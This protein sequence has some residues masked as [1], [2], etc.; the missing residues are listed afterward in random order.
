MLTVALPVELESAIVTAAHR[1]GQSVDEYVATVCAD[2]LSLEM[3][4]ARLDSYL[5]GTPGVQHER[6]R[7]WLD[8]LASGKR[9]EC[10]R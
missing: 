10:P 2:A 6:A 5:S 7:A 9:T 1:S 3:D 4:R 8:E